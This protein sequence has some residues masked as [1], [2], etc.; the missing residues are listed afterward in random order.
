MDA[1]QPDWVDVFISFCAGYMFSRS[2]W[3]HWVSPE[4]KAK[5]TSKED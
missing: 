1:L 5:L 2:V 3:W 4:S